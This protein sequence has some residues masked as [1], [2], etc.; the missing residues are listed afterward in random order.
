MLS[1]EMHFFSLFRFPFLC[2]VSSWLTVPVAATM[3]VASGSGSDSGN[4]GEGESERRLVPRWAEGGGGIYCAPLWMCTYPYIDNYEPMIKGLFFFLRLPPPHI[5]FAPGFMPARMLPRR[6]PQAGKMYIVH[7]CC[8]RQHTGGTGS[9]RFK[10]IHC[11]RPDTAIS[12][13]V[14]TTLRVFA[15]LSVC[16]CTRRCAASIHRVRPTAVPPPATLLPPPPLQCAAARWDALPLGCDACRCTVEYKNGR[17]S[18][19]QTCP[20][21][22]ASARNGYPCGCH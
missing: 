6:W 21:P 10:C 15:R 20:T 7:T 18:L 3:P 1:E 17:N 5:V 9:D 22:Y 11:V 2:N 14:C 4:G 12:R 19:R 16:C 13:Y 8:D